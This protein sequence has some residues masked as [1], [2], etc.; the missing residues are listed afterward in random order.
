MM[1]LRR[2]MVSEGGPGWAVT[3][4][5]GLPLTGRWAT[6]DEAREEGLCGVYLLSG[7]DV[8]YVDAP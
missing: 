3:G 6:S 1:R 4:Y 2:G 8:I 7:C 5:D